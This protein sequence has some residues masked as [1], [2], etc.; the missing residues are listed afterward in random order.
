MNAIGKALWFIESHYA[1]DISL[2]DIAETAGLSRY[3]LSRVFGLT[4]G[5]SISGYIRARRL[6]TAALSLA[7]GAS[8][9]L[10]VALDAGYSS[11]E[12][13][14][15]AF[16]D[17]FGVT[18]E[19]VRNRGHIGDLDLMEPIRMNTAPLPRLDEPRFESTPA[20]LMAGLQQ[21]YNYGAN[22]GIPSQWQQFNAHDGS[23]SGQIGYAAYGIC[24]QEDGQDRS[25]QYM[26]AVEVR[27][28]DNLPKGFVSLKLPAQS[29]AIFA[30]RGHISGIQAT[31][32]AIF[33]EWLPSSGYSHAGLP[34]LMERYDERFDPRTG[35]GLTEIW[36]PV[37]S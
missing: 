26:T 24:T 15:R 34:D 6:S 7:G 8:S 36:L 22:A 14:T 9:I 29:Y 12:A 1:R 31:C 3:H 2:E 23:I 16:R 37:K 11:H 20:M 33:T 18:P 17:H 13:F 10:A 28:T 5:F 21:T 35:M 19:E 4:T 25:F 27:D 30:H 32:A